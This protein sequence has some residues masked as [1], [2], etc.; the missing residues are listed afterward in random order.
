[1]EERDLIETGHNYITLTEQNKRIKQIL[2]SSKQEPIQPI[3]GAE[4]HKVDPEIEDTAKALKAISQ[5]EAKSHSLAIAGKS[6]IVGP[7][8]TVETTKEAK[9][10]NPLKGEAAAQGSREEQENQQ[11]QA[12]AT[13]K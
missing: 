2:C 9:R 1:V 13:I 5:V 11:G 7:T 3:G 6:R 12:V 8:E 10:G 4:G